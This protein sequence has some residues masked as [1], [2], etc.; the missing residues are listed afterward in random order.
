MGHFIFQAPMAG[1]KLKGCL[2][3][4]SCPIVSTLSFSRRYQNTR[5]LLP[6]HSMSEFH[7][8]LYGFDRAET[9][10]ERKEIERYAGWGSPDRRHARG[11]TK[12]SV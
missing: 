11:E 7:N 5:F 9:R 4:K 6:I 2:A 10:S 3:S 12:A 1:F 8:S